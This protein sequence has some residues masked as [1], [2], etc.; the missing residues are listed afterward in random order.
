MS[1]AASNGILRSDTTAGSP[2][3]WS[4]P[5]RAYHRG[6]GLGQP[7]DPTMCIRNVRAGAG[8]STSNNKRPAYETTD[9]QQQ[10][11]LYR[12]HRA[13]V[14]DAEYDGG[15]ESKLRRL[16]PPFLGEDQ[17]QQQQVGGGGG[18][19]GPWAA[20]Q[21][22]PHYQQEQL[23]EDPEPLAG[24]PQQENPRLKRNKPVKW[25][26]EED[27]RLREAVVRVSECSVCESCMASRR[28]KKNAFLILYRAPLVG[29]AGHPRGS[30]I[31]LV[32]VIFAPPRRMRE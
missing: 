4:D 5:S 29:T 32:V 23:M 14:E 24:G 1:L 12:Q 2:L 8:Q 16:T 30:K 19:P 20:S 17:Q 7:S 11:L 6:G 13:P 18:A 27:R 9:D 3:L 31:C 28:K 15:R 22:Q 21:Q 26:A 10:A 25:S